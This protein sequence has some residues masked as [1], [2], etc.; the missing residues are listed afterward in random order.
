MDD[1]EIE[2]MG[3][4]AAALSKLEGDD[5]RARVLRYANERFGLIGAVGT[6]RERQG[7]GQQG[8]AR[9]SQGKPEAE[10]RVFAEF[11]DLFD[12]ANPTTDLDRALVAAYW[13]QVC[14]NQ[15][16]WVSQTVN[17]TLKNM[18]HPIGNITNVMTRAQNHQPS[19][20]RQTA[21]SGKAQQARKTF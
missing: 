21:K 15:A 3:V 7:P 11:V 1:P 10:E 20:V 4:V 2:A 14:Q 18:G 17:D 8:E 16:S 5:A 12:E 13:F 9:V 6:R 19:F